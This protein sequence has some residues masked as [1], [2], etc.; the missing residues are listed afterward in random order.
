L[1]QRIAD[2]KKEGNFKLNGTE[3]FIND[4]YVTR[5]GKSFSEYWLEPVPEKQLELQ[6]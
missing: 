6:F 5:D 2:L 4:E 3:Y 1:A